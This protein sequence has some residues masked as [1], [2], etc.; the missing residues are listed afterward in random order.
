MSGI[1]R[2]VAEKKSVI[3]KSGFKTV[4]IYRDCFL[5]LFYCSQFSFDAYSFTLSHLIFKYVS[6]LQLRNR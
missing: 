2:K 3:A 5:L 1:D 6:K 4:L